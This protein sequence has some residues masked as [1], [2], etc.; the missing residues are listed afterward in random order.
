MRARFWGV[1]GPPGKLKGP[2]QS[3]EAARKVGVETVPV[4][5]RRSWRSPEGRV[6]GAL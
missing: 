5:T 3:R 2:L 4:T 1:C 6:E